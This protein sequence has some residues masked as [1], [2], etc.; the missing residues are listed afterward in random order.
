MTSS[1]IAEG[2]GVAAGTST[3]VAVSRVIVPLP[4]DHPFY[5]VIGRVAAEWS[6]LEHLLD[7]I[8]WDLSGVE[9][10]AGACITAQMMGV[11]NR[12]QAIMALGERRSLSKKIPER[13]NSLT[14]KSFKPGEARNRIVHDT[15]YIKSVSRQLGQFRSMARKIGASG[16]LTSMRL[17]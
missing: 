15:W 4:D 17:T 2:V 14:E 11:G 16:W 12:L 8:I 5:A 9:H 6:Q 1:R 7:I 13:V 3:A 10:D